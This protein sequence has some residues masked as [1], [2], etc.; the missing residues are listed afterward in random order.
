MDFILICCTF[1]TILFCACLSFGCQSICPPSLI[2]LLVKTHTFRLQCDTD[3][4]SDP[5]QV[6]NPGWWRCCSLL[7]LRKQNAAASLKNSKGF[8]IPISLSIE[9][10]NWLDYYFDLLSCENKPQIPS[11][12]MTDTCLSKYLPYLS[13]ICRRFAWMFTD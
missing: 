11:R 7:P 3:W 6:N 10:P 2:T 13:S 8:R 5:S 12:K 4:R 1:M 9:E